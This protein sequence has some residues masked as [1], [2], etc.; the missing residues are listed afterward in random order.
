MGKIIEWSVHRQH[1]LEGGVDG[2]TNK[3][4]DACYGFWIGGLSPSTDNNEFS[5]TRTATRG[6][7][8]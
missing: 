5:W 3:L 1:E 6:E 2:R 7:S 8:I 4:V